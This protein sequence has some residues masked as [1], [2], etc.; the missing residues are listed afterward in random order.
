MKTTY[1]MIA[2]IM[3]LNTSDQF[4]ADKIKYSLPT[5]MLFSLILM[6]TYI[7]VPVVVYVKENTEIR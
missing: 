5:M 2:A 4:T 6:L 1:L 7:N 3:L